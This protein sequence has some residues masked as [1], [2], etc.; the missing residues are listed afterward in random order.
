MDN[1]FFPVLLLCTI[2]RSV[3]RFCAKVNTNS[4]S[5]WMTEGREVPI[6][7]MDPFTTA[8]RAN[9]LN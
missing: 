4:G 9:R 3:T 6:F 5:A 7:K 8:A 2:F 1:M